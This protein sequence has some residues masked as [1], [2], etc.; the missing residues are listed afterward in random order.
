VEQFALVKSMVVNKQL[1][2][3]LNM[4]SGKRVRAPDI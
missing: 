2:S 4:S 3:A 1:T